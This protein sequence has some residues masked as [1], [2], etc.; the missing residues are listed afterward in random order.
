MRNVEKRKDL[1]ITIIFSES[2][3]SLLNLSAPHLDQLDPENSRIFLISPHRYKSI[4][5]S[6]SCTELKEEKPSTSQGINSNILSKYQDIVDKKEA[7]KDSGEAYLQI[8]SN[9]G[10]FSKSTCSSNSCMYEG[11]NSEDSFELLNTKPTDEMEDN[12]N[13]RSQNNLFEARKFLPLPLVTARSKAHENKLNTHSNDI[14]VS[15]LDSSSSSTDHMCR[16]CHGGESLDDLLMPCRCRGTVALVHLKCLERWLKDSQ[17]SYCELCMHHYKI[18]RRPRYS[19]LGSI[20]AYM[21]E[22]GPRKKEIMYDLLA[23]TLYTPT[24]VAST[25]VLMMMCE[26]LVKANIVKT[27]TISSHI[28]AFSAVFGMAAIDFTYSSWL[29]YTCQK[30]AEA[31][32]EWYN[33]TTTVK[34]ILPAIKMRPIKGK[35]R[36]NKERVS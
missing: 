3:A 18:E 5:G 22:P 27:G 26:T 8:S 36:S 16:I 1:C 7:E 28:L 6:V 13:N 24:A 20:Y 31:W 34:V 14:Y 32:R 25:Y 21:K 11:C 30:H 33:N 29:L 2:T 4:K 17:H 12:A 35:R 9:V 23:L 10:L 15:L 19:I